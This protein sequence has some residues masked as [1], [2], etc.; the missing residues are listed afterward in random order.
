MAFQPIAEICQSGDNCSTITLTDITG[1]Y[2]AE[3]NSNGWNSPNPAY[4]NIVS[5][6]LTIDGGT[7]IALTAP[8]SAIVGTFAYADITVDLADGYHTFVYT[9][10][11]EGPVTYTYSFQA[12]L[13]CQSRKCIDNMWK[14][15]AC[16]DCECAK[17]K[18]DQIMRAEA[19]LH[20]IK[21]GAYSGKSSEVTEMINTIA[22]ICAADDCN[23]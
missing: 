8:S 16:L 9:V 14:E 22:A 5:V 18:G 19:I 12:L 4:G 21:A 3:N 11:T 2:D 1:V 20:S 15:Y 10:I 7:P 23:C 13:L 17:I 6:S